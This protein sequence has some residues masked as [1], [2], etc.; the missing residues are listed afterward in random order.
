MTAH[1]TPRPVALEVADDATAIRTRAFE[2]A[3]AGDIRGARAD[4]E[5]HLRG[6]PADGPAH[7]LHAATLMH[8][9]DLPGAI[10]AF[11][12]AIR[13]GCDD[14]STHVQLG[15][16]LKFRGRC[17]DAQR[18]FD[19]ACKLDPA[20][21]IARWTSTIASLPMVYSD[22]AEIAA[23]LA[24]FVA[25][26]DGLERW[27]IDNAAAPADAVVGE[28]NPF[29]LA[30]L[31]R[32][33]RPELARYG[34]LCSRLMAMWDGGRPRAAPAVVAD[35]RTRIGLVSRYFYRHSV[36][37]AIVKGMMRT[38]DPARFRFELFHVGDKRDAETDFA[39]GL[40]ASYVPSLAHTDAA[41]DAIRQAVP[42][43]LLYPE[44][45]MDPLS[46]R[47]AAL[48]LAPLQIA[49]WGHPIT[50]G[51]PTIDRFLSAAAFEPAGAADHYTETLVALPGLGAR[52][53]REPA[54]PLPVDFA[55]FGIDP[56]RP[57]FV[58]PGVPW[59]YLP[60]FDE[61]LCAI[62][63]RVPDAQFVFFRPA[64]QLAAAEQ[65]RGRI[66]R[67][68]TAAGIAPAGRIVFVPWLGRGEFLGLVRA[69]VACLDAFG[70][71][72]FNTVLQCL[73][74][75]TPMV[76]LA[77]RYMRGR[78]ASGVLGHVG[79]DEFVASDAA[80]YVERAVACAGRADDAALRMHIAAAVEKA[81]DDPA[82]MRALGE[83]L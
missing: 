8:T 59:K 42:D 67:R 73:Q 47:L 11:Q 33:N 78:L 43:I 34:K 24:R 70:F 3:A 55:T 21:G 60:A 77:G 12:L 65:L 35:P 5:L 51:L 13:H 68:L 63:S 39:R 7:R 19:R 2:R 37:T 28:P 57:I 62:A 36:W 45:G 10:N 14:A 66:S 26:L 53:E 1:G 49:S 27:W 15:L 44:I 61:A 9:G 17:A 48:R 81:F 72:G 69:A 20:D 16:S 79:L 4:I 58:C 31:E 71:S 41:I 22:E 75:G 83:L 23:V 46:T 6:A 29:H 18:H 64:V 38:F 50:T 25:R 82:P 52:I 54:E 80:G 30:Y 40:A 32:D 76:T 74:V 56:H